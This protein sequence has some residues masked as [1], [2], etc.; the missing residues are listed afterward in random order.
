M[1]IMRKQFTI[2]IAGLTIGIDTVSTSACVLCRDYLC[3]GEPDFVIRVEQEDIEK[4]IESYYITIFKSKNIKEVRYDNI[5]QI[6]IEDPDLINLLF[7]IREKKDK[8]F[9]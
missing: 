3:E 6:L 5:K 9:N 4:E 2:R 1:D 8:L 7:Y